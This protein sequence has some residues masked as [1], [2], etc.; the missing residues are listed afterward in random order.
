MTKND[1]LFKVLIFL[2]LFIFF[3]CS[4]FAKEPA[5]YVIGG[6]M[7]TEES[8]AYDVAG[9]DLFLM[10][11]SDKKIS[12][13]TLV[14]F[15]FDEDGNPPE[16]ARNSIVLTVSAEVEPYDS[17]STCLSLDKYV[18]YVLD[19]PYFVDYMYLSKIVY[20]NGTQWTDPFGTQVF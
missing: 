8:A 12:E 9:L 11:K 3:S 4:L 7:V 5:P 16:G 20:E 6:E 1:F 19:E 2:S 13:F 14:F 18:Y 17:L 10:N 15:I